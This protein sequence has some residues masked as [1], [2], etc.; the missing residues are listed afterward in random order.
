VLKIRVAAALGL[1]AA[2]AALAAVALSGLALIALA[3][4]PVAT[5]PVGVRFVAAAVAAA[6]LVAVVFVTLEV[7]QGVRGPARGAALPPDHHPRLWRVADALADSVGVAPPERLVLTPG[8]GLRVRD[9]AGR[10]ELAIGA[11]ALRSLTEREFE[12]ALALELAD[13]VAWHPGAAHRLRRALV[14]LDQLLTGAPDGLVRSLVL[15][16]ARQVARLSYPLL[17]ENVYLSDAC[18]AQ[19]CGIPG[20]TAAIEAT[21]SPGP[22]GRLHLLPVVPTLS[23]R[24]RRLTRSSA[25]RERGAHGP[26]QRALDRVNGTAVDRPGGRGDRASA[27]NLLDLGRSRAVRIDIDARDLAADQRRSG[28]RDHLAR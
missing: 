3:A 12:A 25:C 13:H 22:R 2:P 21:Y 7:R 27:A 20:T 14:R 17:M 26:E 19:V 28:G 15:A 9:V 10:R 16:H 8:G 5:W 6:L 1:L 23:C 11:Q 24:L 4:G 18:V